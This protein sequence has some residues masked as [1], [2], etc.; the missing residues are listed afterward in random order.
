MLA[1]LFHGKVSVQAHGFGRGA[2]DDT[3]VFSFSSSAFA[4]RGEQMFACCVSVFIFARRGYAEAFLRA[5][6]VSQLRH[7]FPLLLQFVDAAP[8]LN[9]R[10]RK[11]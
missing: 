6:I 1:P 11:T 4:L 3:D 9:A 10:A 5:G 7:I 2:A 8:P